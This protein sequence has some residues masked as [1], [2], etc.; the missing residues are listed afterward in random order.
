M[1]DWWAASEKSAG[2]KGISLKDR[3]EIAQASMAQGTAGEQEPPDIHCWANL[4][5]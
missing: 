5:P 1:A 3:N 4:H 2:S